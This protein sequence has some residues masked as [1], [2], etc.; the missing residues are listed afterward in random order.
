[1]GERTVGEPLADK[2]KR[3]GLDELVAAIIGLRLDV[4]ADNEKPS[5]HEAARGA[6]GATK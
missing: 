6:A 3:I 2:L 4:D 5:L 1:L